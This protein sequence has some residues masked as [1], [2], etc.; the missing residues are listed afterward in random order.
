MVA[1]DY[2][3]MSCQASA[4]FTEFSS[5]FVES[6]PDS[7]TS[8]DVLCATVIFFAINCRHAICELPT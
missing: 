8:P 4:I 7:G 3:L 2:A 6:S 5:W 1:I